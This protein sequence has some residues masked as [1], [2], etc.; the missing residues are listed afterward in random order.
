MFSSAWGTR[1]VLDTTLVRPGLVAAV[2][3]DTSIDRGGVY[4]HPVR[5][6]RLRLD[7]TVDDVPR[8]GG[9]PAAAAE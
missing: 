7:A 3:A 8:F 1:D 5:Y 9:G 2:S 6:V 4:R